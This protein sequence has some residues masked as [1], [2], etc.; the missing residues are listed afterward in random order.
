MRRGVGEQA[1]LANI[2][3][4]KDLT[5][6]PYLAQNS[7]VLAAPFFAVQAEPGCTTLRSISKP[8]LVLCR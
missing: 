4:G 2:Q 5:A 8:L 7:L 1:N 3:V 6:K